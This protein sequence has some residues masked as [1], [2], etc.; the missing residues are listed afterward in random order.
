MFPR[1]G[2]YDVGEGM[3]EMAN[4]FE[5]REISI[6]LVKI[7]YNGNNDRNAIYQTYTKIGSD[8]HIEAKLMDL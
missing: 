5:A 1:L 7:P 6:E 2:K 4:N 8:N 3:L